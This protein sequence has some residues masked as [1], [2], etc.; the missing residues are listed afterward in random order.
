MTS[1]AAI[2]QSEAVLGDEFDDA[3]RSRL[4]DALR[5][6]GATVVGHGQAFAGSQD[7]ESLEVE[8]DGRRLHIEAET[9]VGLS[10]RGP[11]DL[12]QRVRELVG[13]KA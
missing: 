2:A 6:I 1:S 5:Q 4:M 7:L 12:V 13:A 11:A 8:V 3:L 10:V 9:Y